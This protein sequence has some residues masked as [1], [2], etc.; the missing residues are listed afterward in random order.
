M[1][2]LLLSLI[3]MPK[4]RTSYRIILIDGLRAVSEFCGRM[5]GFFCGNQVKLQLKNSLI[6][7]RL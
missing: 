3:N 5:F 1:K 7:L 4:A 6:G 2:I